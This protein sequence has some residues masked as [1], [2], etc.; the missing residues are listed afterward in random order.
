M[1][2]ITPYIDTQA[3]LVNVKTA[4]NTKQWQLH[5]TEGT[6][7]KK[8]LI[9]CQ[10][11]K[12]AKLLPVQLRRMQTILMGSIRPP[13]RLKYTIHADNDKCSHPPMQRRHG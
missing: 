6:G 3:T 5:G 10:A 12:P 11:F 2:G 13:R 1:Q 9:K 4:K 8:W 7:S